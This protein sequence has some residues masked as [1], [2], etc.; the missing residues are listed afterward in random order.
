M[1]SQDTIVHCA[2]KIIISQLCEIHQYSMCVFCGLQ[3]NFS[4]T[5]SWAQVPWSNVTKLINAYLA[6][7]ASCVSFYSLILMHD[8][9]C[10]CDTCCCS[11]GLIARCRNMDW[12]IEELM[13]VWCFVQLSRCM[14]GRA[15]HLVLTSSGWCGIFRSRSD[16][17]SP[18]LKI[19]V[20]V[21]QLPLNQVITV[22]QLHV[23]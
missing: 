8:I 22:I 19:S 12:S 7:D 10:M 20:L 15:A 3:V 6:N 9:N 11:Y 18:S 17:W 4:T 16:I 23:H 1:R 5:G 13:W 21:H 14:I 2:I